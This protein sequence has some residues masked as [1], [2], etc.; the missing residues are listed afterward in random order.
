MATT[1]PPLDRTGFIGGS[2]IGAV[3]GINPYKSRLQLWLEKTGQLE[4]GADNP[5]TRRGREL[6]PIAAKL[7]TQETGQRLRRKP[8]TIFHPSRPF[9]AAHVDR[10]IV[11]TSGLAEIKCPSLGAYARIK[12]EGLRADY[13]A[14]MQWYLGLA[15][16]EFGEWIIFCAD[17]WQLLHFPVRFDED[18]YVTMLR[19]AQRFWDEHVVPR[20]PPSPD[21]SDIEFTKHELASR[22]SVVKSDPAFVEAMGFLKEAKQLKREAELLDEAA[23]VRVKELVGDAPGTYTGPGYRLHLIAQQG[24]ASFDK[25][26][27]AAN[28]P[29]D[30]LKVGAVLQPFLMRTFDT[31]PEEIESMIQRVG[32]CE[33]DLAQFEKRGADFTTLR[34]YFFAEGD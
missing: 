2:D 3:L 28:R 13:V 27:L 20:V 29:L 6:E 22:G 7:F 24:R 5:H 14:Q 31:M 11:G 25:Q 33:I 9:L 19:E 21:Q 23:K 12:R 32:Q 10:E 1:A 34:P 18:L 8:R 16:K 15:A 17:Q 26:A 4:P 30:R